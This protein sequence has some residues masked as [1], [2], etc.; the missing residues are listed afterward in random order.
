MDRRS[1]GCDHDLAAAYLE[2]ARFDQRKRP[3]R[4]GLAS[5]HRITQGDDATTR[6]VAKKKLAL[7]VNF[8]Y[9]RYIRDDANRVVIIYLW[10]IHK[11]LHTMHVCEHM[12]A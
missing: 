5:R 10:C 9:I 4:V 12:R 8:I 2:L 3:S 1:S 6:R 11:Y 7:A